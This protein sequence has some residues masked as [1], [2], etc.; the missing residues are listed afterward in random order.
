MRASL[1]F[2]EG[3]K[4]WIDLP[5]KS[6]RTAPNWTLTI[7]DLPILFT[8]LVVKNALTLPSITNSKWCI[9]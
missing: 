5:I 9:F 8:A 2:L 7:P 4:I 3:F 1:G 6:C